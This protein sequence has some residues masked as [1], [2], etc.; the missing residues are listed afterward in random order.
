[1]LKTDADKGKGR[2]RRAVRQER[3]VMADDRVEE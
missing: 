1:V 2:N 3:D